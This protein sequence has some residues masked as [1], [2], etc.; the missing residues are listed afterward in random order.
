MPCFRLC[1]PWREV[2]VGRLHAALVRRLFLHYYGF[3]D[4]YY[5]LLMLWFY[6]HH[7]DGQRHGDGD[8]VGFCVCVF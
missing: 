6:D 2:G 7:D 5:D 4:S 8:D 3:M 1:Y